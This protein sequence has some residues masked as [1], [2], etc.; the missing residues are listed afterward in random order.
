[1]TEMF[2]LGKQTFFK[3]RSFTCFS[4][5]PPQATKKQAQ[6]RLVPKGHAPDMGE[7]ALHSGQLFFS[8][9]RGTHK[10]FKSADF[11]KEKHYIFTIPSQI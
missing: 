11:V 10:E 2:A 7:A 3:R 5:T 9:E 8:K 1:M 6:I 4:M